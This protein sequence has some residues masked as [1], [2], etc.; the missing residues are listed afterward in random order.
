MDVDLIRLQAQL[1][2]HPQVTAGTV[3]SVDDDLG[4]LEHH[5]M[6]NN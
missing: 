3:A 2:V 1:L 4:L 5:R 6:N